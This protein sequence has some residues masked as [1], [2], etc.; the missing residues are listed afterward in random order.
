MS[1]DPDVP[2]DSV[3]RADRLRRSISVFLLAVFVGLVALRVANL[4]SRHDEIVV[5]NRQLAESLAHV[6]GAHLAQNI[7]TIDAALSQV[8]LHSER[9]GGPNAQPPFWEP[10]VR[11]AF[12][13]LTGAGSL[14]IINDAGIIAHSTI[15]A[16]V[17]ETRS[18]QYIFRHMK[19]NPSAVFLA[20]TPFRSPIG[21]GMLIPFGRRLSTPDGNFDG[22]AVVTLVPEQLR[23]FYRS[24]NVGTD[25]RISVLHPQGIV[26]FNE[27]SIEDSIGRS[28]RDNP[29]FQAAASGTGD[30]FLRAPL[31]SGGPVYLNAYRTVRNANLILTVSISEERVFAAWHGEL[32]NSLGVIGA[33]G[34]LL[35]FAGYLINREIRARAA[36]DLALTNNQA[37]FHEMM[38]HAPILVSVK[39][40]DG[41]IRFINKS[42]EALFG[43]SMKEV[44]GKKLADIDALGTSPGGLIT[45]L[46]QEVIDTKTPIQRE[47]SYP[48]R[49]GTR[50]ALFVKFPLFDSNGT[51]D[52]VASF[53]MDLTEQRRAATWFR[54][55]MDNAP[56]LIALKDIEGRFVFVNRAQ[57]RASGVKAS[58]FLGRTSRD[59]FRREYA[60][61]HDQFDREVLA[62]GAPI[63]REF[64]APYTAGNRMLLFIKFPVFDAKGN[65]EFLGSIAT[66][67]TAQKQAESQLVHAQ[68]MEAVGQLTGGIAH[69]FNNLLTVMIGNSELLTA[70]LADNERLEPLA[71][72]TLEAAERS[73]TLTQRLLAFGRRQMLEPRSTDV[74]R[75]MDDMQDL[76]VRAAGIQAKIEIRPAE[77]DL[78][79]ALVDPG[80]LETA[81]LNLVV[82]SRDAMPDGGRIVIDLSNAKI[83]ESYL[84]LN[85][86]AKAG[87]YVMIAVSDTGTGMPPEV[88][89]RVF[90]P[91]FTTKEAGKGTGLGLP[92]IYGF[93]KQSGGHVTVY[94]E[95]GHGT[96]VRVYIPRAN[97]TGI[98]PELPPASLE[99]LPRGQESILLVEDDR[100]VRAY[101]E[102]QLIDLGY[103]VTTA[104]SPGEAMKLAYLTGRPDL[105]VTDI[106]MA[107]T[108]N[109]RQLAERMR[110]RWP[111]IKVLYVSGYADGILPELVDGQADGINFL[112]KPFRRRDLALKVREVLDG[113]KE[114]ASFTV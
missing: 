34:G 41:R 59:L 82:N 85:P 95:V 111:D 94:S 19:E 23:D 28:A 103:R 13:G 108:M 47:L 78:W 77:D 12:A 21:H 33:L 76:I 93:V 32:R 45:S 18:D 54:T 57:E 104:A 65:I 43:L 66:D 98:V 3:V 74:G 113:G 84:E 70:A 5:E 90:E 100:A 44:M 106:I 7:A 88:V 30:G 99:H 53:S 80:Q 72:M 79:P 68:R 58:E 51:V 69:D 20:D 73:A 105:L 81:I 63:Q 75:L 11:A 109:G 8:A 61:L 102:G 26:L 101:T 40:T 112:A 31:E 29:L 114:V 91:F 4:W 42:L 55:I 22:F 96:V 37:R 1:D 50:T 56:A 71:R 86:D 62:T 16:I 110:E 35:L 15:D 67:V 9:V 38:Y 52:S 64:S 25:G 87:D 48:T 27:P 36:A 92:T 2:N 39:G 10:V 60:D 24:V 89:E 97:A 46:D 83:D 49:D 107:G 6:L 14:S 17:G